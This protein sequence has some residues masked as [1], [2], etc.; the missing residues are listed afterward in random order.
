MTTPQLN[1]QAAEVLALDDARIEAKAKLQVLNGTDASDGK[2]YQAMSEANYTEIMVEK[3]GALAASI[4]RQLLARDA[5]KD[6]EIAALTKEAEDITKNLSDCINERL[7]LK[8]ELRKAQ[9]RREDNLLAYMHTLE[10]LGNARGSIAAL[11]ERADVAESLRVKDHHMATQTRARLEKQLE[12]AMVALG[13]ISKEG[14]E[15]SQQEGFYTRWWVEP[16]PAAKIAQ[17][18][19]AAL[20]K[21]NSIGE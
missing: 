20:E 3:K 9:D 17:Q 12:M 5:A 18:C 15:M 2:F 6:A 10:A 21:F 8:E 14:K 4:I 11:K 13:E 7:A 16:S 1:D 19:L